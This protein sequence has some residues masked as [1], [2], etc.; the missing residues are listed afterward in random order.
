MVR[1]APAPSLTHRINTLP[2][3]T[4]ECRNLLENCIRERGVVA[5]RVKTLTSCRIAS[6]RVIRLFEKFP[7]MLALQAPHTAPR[8]A[9]AWHTCP[10]TLVFVA[11]EAR[12]SYLSSRIRVIWVSSP[13]AS[14]LDRSS[15][16]CYFP[17][18]VLPRNPASP[19]CRRPALSGC[20]RRKSPSYRGPL[21]WSS[22]LRGTAWSCPSWERRE[23]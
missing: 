20:D 8:C 3:R 14:R 4:I 23:K 6:L 11:P 17:S 2:C 15:K 16:W 19:S 21:V 13:E 9:P 7:G 1:P 22:A 10:L 18:P 5:Q 12:S